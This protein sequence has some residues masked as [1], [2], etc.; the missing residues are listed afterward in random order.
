MEGKIND[1]LSKSSQS[2]VL[3]TYI[4]DTFHTVF[5]VDLNLICLKA[6]DMSIRESKYFIILCPSFIF[7][8][9]ERCKS[10]AAGFN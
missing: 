8:R 4:S 3:S 7:P 9:G 5:I 10:A 1:K 2:Q 6:M